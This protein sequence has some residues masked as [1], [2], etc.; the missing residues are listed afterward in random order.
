MARPIRPMSFGGLLGVTL[1]CVIVFFAVL[2]LVSPQGD[3]APAGSLGQT[4]GWGL[5]LIML[6]LIYDQIVQVVR[7]LDERARSDLPE[8]KRP[9]PPPRR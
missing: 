2:F 9:L 5:Q 7:R 3:P 1:G 4:I 8:A 6:S